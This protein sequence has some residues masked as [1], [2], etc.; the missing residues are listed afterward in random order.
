MEFARQALW[1][2]LDVQIISTTEAWA[3]FA[4]AG[5]KSRD[6]LRKVVDREHD[7]SNEGFPFM[8]CGEISVGGTRAR[9]F[10]ISFSGELAYEIAVPARY[11]NALMEALMEAGEE[12]GATPY[13]TEALGVMRIEKGHVTGNELNG[14][15]TALNIG[16][17]RMVSQ[18]KDSIGTVNSRREGLNEADALILVG[19]KPVNA[20]E[21]VVPGSHLMAETGEVHAKTDQGYVTSAAFSPHI[22]SSIG[23]GFLKNGGARMGERLRAVNPLQNQEVLVEVVSAHFID[24]EGERLRG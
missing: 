2:D 12:F 23:L 5:P 13:G 20:A 15:T 22:G 16:L 7:L 18:K 10:R 3:Q 4:V 14:T 17:G 19:L 11:G 1:P 9:L 24:P 21:P 8:A 6:L